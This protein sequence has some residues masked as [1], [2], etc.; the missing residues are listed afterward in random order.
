MAMLQSEYI[1]SML[2]LKIIKVIK[3]TRYIIPTALITKTTLIRKQ[4][5]NIKE[6][7]K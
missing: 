1:P 6:M 4:P 2:F 7:K 3:L 5:T